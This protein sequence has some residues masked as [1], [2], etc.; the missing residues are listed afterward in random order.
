MATT[1]VTQAQPVLHLSGDV[2]TA[3]SADGSQ[4]NHGVPGPDYK[5]ARFLPSYDQSFK[6]PPLEP[7]EHTDPGLAA[8]N[9]PEPRS[10]LQ[11]AQVTELSPNFGSEVEGI[12]L[13]KLDQRAKRW[14]LPESSWLI[15]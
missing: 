5:Y 14:V 11:G 4:T 1:T 7:F 9:D 13:S 2:E 8:L 3:N 10:F 12:Q 6:L 15:L